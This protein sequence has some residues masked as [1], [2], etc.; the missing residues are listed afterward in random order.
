[1]ADTSHVRYRPTILLPPEAAARQGSPAGVVTRTA[2]MIIDIAVLALATAAVYL[3]WVLVRFIARPA[4]FHWEMLRP[5][6]LIPL[7]MVVAVGVLTA[8]WNL[9]GRTPG[10]RVMGLRVTSRSGARLGLARSFLRAVLYVVFP[11]GLFWC[12]FSRR[13]A[14]VQD[15]IVGSRVIYYWVALAPAEWVASGAGPSTTP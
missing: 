13:R 2:A 9:W 15:L 11:L 8:T 4:R 3:T 10:D 1:M 14:S 7:A 12:T 5:Q 6:Y